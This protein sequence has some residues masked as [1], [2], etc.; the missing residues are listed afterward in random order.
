[1][2]L[3]QVF[4]I[5]DVLIPDPGIHITWLRVRIR[6]RFLLFFFLQGGF[7]DTNEEVKKKKILGAYYLLQVL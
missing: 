1:M 7:Q 2:Y 5:R 3:N 6:P 4:R